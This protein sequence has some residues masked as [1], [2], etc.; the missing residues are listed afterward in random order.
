MYDTLPN[1]P[2]MLLSFVNTQLRDH[3]AS[4]CEFCM[5]YMVDAGEL[6]REFDS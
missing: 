2:V 6:T 1:D 5:V 4:F 3:Y